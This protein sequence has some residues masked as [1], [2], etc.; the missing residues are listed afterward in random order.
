MDR[1]PRLYLHGVFDALKNLD[2][3]AG[4]GADRFRNEYL[5]TMV[6]GEI[7]SSMRSAALDA[8]KN[9]AE[10]IVNND[11]PSWFYMVWCTTVQFAPVKRLGA[12]PAE[13]DVRPI[14]CGGSVRRAVGRCVLLEKKEALRTHCEPVQLAM[15][16][17]A[18]TQ[19]HGYIV[20]IHMQAFPLHICVKID[21]RNAFNEIQRAKIVEIFAR[22]EA[23]RD[24]HRFAESH[25]RPRARIYYLSGG[26]LVPLDYRSV[27]GAA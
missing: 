2:R 3:N 21:F 14:G 10:H 9:F 11:L 25:L 1:A 19:A 16:T 26:K 24:L 15:G 5:L 6:R 23:L 4:A 7:P 18:G 22:T 27:Q 20:G 17:S 8:W 12:T 13:D